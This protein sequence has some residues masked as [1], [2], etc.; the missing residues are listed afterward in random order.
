MVRASSVSILSVAFFVAGCGEQ[1]VTLSVPII[2]H[3]PA[4]DFQANGSKNAAVP[5]SGRQEVPA[6]PTR[7]RGNATFHVSEDGSS[8]DYKLIAA[9]IDNPWQAHIHLG[10]AGSNGP[11]VVFL[12]GPA[13]PGSGSHNGIL[14]EGSFTAAD[15]VGSL[16]GMTMGDLLAE[17][18]AGNA[19]VNLHT[20]DGMAG[21]NTGPGDFLSGE[22]RGQVR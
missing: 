12:F 2:D 8:V 4:L 20:N 1:D 17:M 15:F 11:V 22:V 21:V 14:A 13:T 3:T 18:S 19:Y 9:N 16:T 10:P 6:R 5:M 7:A